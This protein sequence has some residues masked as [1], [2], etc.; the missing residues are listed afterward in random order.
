MSAILKSAVI[1]LFAL[2][3]LGM[4]DSM[5]CNHRLVGKGTSQ[6]EV[7]LH[8]GEPAF[9]QIV[10]EPV[11]TQRALQA[12]F[13]PSRR[14][15]PEPSG[16]LYGLESEQEYIEIERWT[17]HPSSGRLIREVDFLDGKILRINTTGR[18]P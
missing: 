12:E 1:A 7:L 10:R 4:A 2:P 11:L 9:S 15:Q 14:E 3:A 8:C 6:Y 17:F 13:Y 16:Y 5:R 18:A